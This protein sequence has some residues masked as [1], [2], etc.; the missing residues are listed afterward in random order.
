MSYFDLQYATMA[1]G[2]AAA[3]RGE[4]LESNPYPPNLR[5]EEVTDYCSS[6]IDS[7]EPDEIEDALAYLLNDSWSE[8]HNDHTRSEIIEAL[9]TNFML[10][11][12][13]DDESA[14]TYGLTG[15]AEREFD[16]GQSIA[17]NSPAR[18]GE[19]DTD[20]NGIEYSKEHLE[21][22]LHAACGKSSSNP[23][24]APSAGCAGFTQEEWHR[25]YTQYVDFE[26]GYA[27]CSYS[28]AMRMA[29]KF[30][31]YY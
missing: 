30:S 12:N 18:K 28:A 1:E 8:G 15:E 24:E 31:P 26:T 2:T 22:F 9:G 3:K 5:G 23:Y 17:S 20:A 19:D 16:I 27:W 11:W 29:R 13:S 14:S 10:G 4:S 6:N 25:M 7:C 21:G